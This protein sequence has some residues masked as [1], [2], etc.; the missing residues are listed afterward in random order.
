VLA[1]RGEIDGPV[2]LHLLVGRSAPAWI[3]PGV[4]LPGGAARPMFPVRVQGINP[5]LRDAVV[6]AN[7]L[8]SALREGAA[9]GVLD[10]AGRAVHTEREP[11]LSR[12]LKP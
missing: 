1:E 9:P 8:V 10:A 2:R 12:A 7:H 5:A 6:A 4:L 3:A 11:G